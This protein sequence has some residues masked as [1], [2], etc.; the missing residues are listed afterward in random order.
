MQGG[1]AQSV[2]KEAADNLAAVHTDDGINAGVVLVELSDRLSGLFGNH[3][4]VFDSR[5]IYII[6]DVR[7]VRRK[8]AGNNAQGDVFI[9]AARDFHASAFHG[10]SPFEIIWVLVSCSIIALLSKK[11]R[12]N[13]TKSKKETQGFPQKRV[14]TKRAA[15]IKHP[16][17]PI[18]DRIF[19]FSDSC[20]YLS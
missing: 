8:M 4:A 20:F 11:S 6:I 14:L 12:M 5:H 10:I 15:P 13:P 19:P 16:V 17:L 2:S 3:T 1:F 18:Q 7:M 9:S